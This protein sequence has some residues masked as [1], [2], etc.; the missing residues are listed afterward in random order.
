ML[1]QDW[2]L[3]SVRKEYL[4]GFATVVYQILDFLSHLYEL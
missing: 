4:K 1:T 2:H 3:V